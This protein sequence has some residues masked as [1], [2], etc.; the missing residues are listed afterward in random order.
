MRFSKSTI[1]REGRAMEFESITKTRMQ[2]VLSTR[3]LSQLLR[4]GTYGVFQERGCPCRACSGRA[5]SRGFGWK[6]ITGRQLDDLVR[7]E[8]ESGDGK[9]STLDS[10]WCSFT[11]SLRA[12]RYPGLCQSGN[13]SKTTPERAA[14]GSEGMHLTGTQIC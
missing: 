9:T 14:A 4:A 10:R 12:G 8:T 2:E 7:V 3:K 11:N 1:N 6:S 13:E 5:S